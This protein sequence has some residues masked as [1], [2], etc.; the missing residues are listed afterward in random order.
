VEFQITD[1]HSFYR[2]LDLQISRAISD[3]S[4]VWRFREALTQA[5][6]VKQRF[7]LFTQT[8]ARKKA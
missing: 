3:F 8:L 4:T 2:F 7:A 1:R 6:V 5:G